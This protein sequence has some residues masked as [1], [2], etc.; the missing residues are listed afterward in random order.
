LFLFHHINAFEEDGEL[1]IDVAGYSDAEW[2]A[3]ITANDSARP[4]QFSKHPSARRYVLPLN[5]ESA[6]PG[7]NLVKSNTTATAS[8]RK[9]TT[10][11]VDLTAHHFTK[12]MFELP[13]INYKYNGKKY[14]YFYG[15]TQTKPDSTYEFGM[16][17]IGKVDISTGEETNWVADED[18]RVSE[19]IFVANPT[20]PNGK[21]DDGVIL[22][23]LLP[24]KNPTSVSL[25]ILDA[26]T[27]A[28]IARSDFVAEGIVTGTF[29]G[30][31]AQS[32][33]ALHV[34]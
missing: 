27:M 23:A 33:E 8:L 19:P 30:Q 11:T 32:G 24:N 1:I 29:H 5:V 14:N 3:K 28:E 20:K 7:E 15:V 25:V 21:E 4:G 10:S 31:W 26:T 13:R 12:Y 22:A 2:V 17:V 16:D 6:Q 34:Y 9:G 18:S